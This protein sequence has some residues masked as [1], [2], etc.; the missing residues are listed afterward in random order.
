MRRLPA[1]ALMLALAIAGCGSSSSS[2]SDEVK[3]TVQTYYTA[4]AAGN[5]A[6][7]CAVLA[8]SLKQLL[9]GHGGHSCE[10]QA[11]SAHRLLAGRNLE[12]LNHAKVESAS[13]NGEHA[14]ATVSSPEGGTATV[15]LVKT[16]SGWRIATVSGVP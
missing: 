4:L 6:A 8:P 1:A 7:A 11:S 3:S 2:P 16:S 15:S 5:G 14:T 10:V 12:A 13:V 9:E